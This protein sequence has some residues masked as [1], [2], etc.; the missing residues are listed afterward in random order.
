MNKKLTV[1]LVGVLTAGAILAAPHR[2]AHNKGHHAHRTTVHHHVR[3]HHHHHGGVWGRGGR[4]FWPGFVGGV[5]GG[6]L[7]DTVI[8]PRVV[9]T[10]VVVTAPTVVTV[11]AVTATQGVVT[12]QVWVPG[13][14]VLQTQP[15]GSFVRV[16]QAGHYEMAVR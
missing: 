2:G 13:R 14:Y 1:V 10:P 8:A 4:N 5:V 6:V 16:W 7:T 9:T 12:E 11:P 3:H 15:N